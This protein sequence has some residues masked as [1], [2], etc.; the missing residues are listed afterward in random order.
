MQFLRP[1]PFPTMQVGQGST[2]VCKPGISKVIFQIFLLKNKD[3]IVV[4]V[5]RRILGLVSS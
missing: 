2:H 4:N 3:D 5:K 1:E